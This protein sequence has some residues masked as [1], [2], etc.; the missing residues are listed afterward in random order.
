MG[1]S[2]LGGCFPVGT[3]NFKALFS[4]VKWML[5]RI[6]GNQ[7]QRRLRKL[8]PLVE[9]INPI[10]EDLK[11]WK[12]GDLRA[13]TV[14]WKDYLS[15][16]EEDV[17]YFA[18]RKIPHLEP[19]K[20]D[21]ILEGWETRFRRLEKDFPDAAGHAERIREARD[22]TEAEK[23]AAAIHRAQETYNRMREKFPDLRAAYLEEIL[24]TA[25]AV[26]KNTARRLCGKT[27]T[28]SDQPTPWD[29]VHFDVQLIGGAGLHQGNI[30]EMA[31]GEGKTLVAT[32]PVYLNALTGL[33]VHVITVNDYLAKRD[34][35][36]MGEL[37]RWLGLT[38][39]CI[40]N[41]MPPDARKE[42]Y[43]RDITYG[44]ASEFGFDYLRD[45]GMASTTEEQVQRGHYY[46]LIDEVDSILID[47]ARTPLI[48]SGPVASPMTPQ[49]ER[50][51]PLISQLVKKQQQ[52][53]NEFANDAK[54]AY[55]KGDLE[56]CGLHL[57][58]VKLGQPRH[59]QLLRMMEDAETRR[60]M[61]K[62][63]LSFYQDA[64]KRELFAIKEE[65]YFTIDEKQHDADLSEKGREFLNPEDPEAFVLPDLATSFSEIDGNPALTEEQ[66][67]ETKQKLQSEMD[68]QAQ[69]MHAVSQLLK[70]YCL[71]ER[72]VD[73]MVS[74]NK[75]VILDENTGRPMP[76]RRWSDG[77]HQAVEAKEGVKVDQETQTLATITIQNY[78]RMYEK[79]A[80]MTGTA[81][82]ESAEFKD[83]YG[84]NVLIVPTNKPVARFDHN[85]RVYKTQR[86]KLNAVVTHVKEAHATGQPMLLGTASERSSEI[87]SKMLKRERITHNVLNAKHHRQEAEIV[88]R[89]GHRGAVTVATNM[90]GRG[91]DIKLGEGV[92]EVGGLLVI[93]TERHPSRRIDRQ[94]RGRSGRQGDPGASIFYVSFEDD[95]MRQY[96]ASERMTKLMDRLNL[97]EGQE[98]EGTLLT[99]TIEMAQKKVEER[100]YLRRKWVLQYDDVM[101]QQRE[102]IYGYRNEVL[103]TEDPR[104]LILE[105][106]E[107]GIPARVE[108]YLGSEENDV[109]RDYDGLLGWAN[110][111]FPIRLSSEEADLPSKTHAEIEQLL[112]DRI[113]SA[114]HLKMEH[115]NPDHADEL[116][117]MI[118]LMA[119]DDLWR[120]HLYAMDG[121]REAIGWRAQ[122]QKDPLVEYK[123]E[124]YTLFVDLMDSIKLE[125]LNNLFRSTTNVEGFQAFL[126]KISSSKQDLADLFGGDQ[127]QQSARIAATQPQLR[128]EGEEEEEG[129]S[130]Q[131]PVRREM[132]KVGRNEPCPCGSGKKFKQCCGRKA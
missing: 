115:E 63:E 112:I 75:V 77:L 80:G 84:V 105:I 27:I 101:N 6:V 128:S 117:R 122:G 127:P 50:F 121:L 13:K 74:D 93:G 30:A 69:K 94:L 70:A 62:A 111:T 36:W 19:E 28:V 113:R 12:D 114:Y 15:R 119:I 64:Q 49:F 14:E 65:L 66:K 16:Y 51:K 129:P 52:L 108:Q 102:V 79:M 23:R 78:F 81:E 33:G 85:D 68:V 107:D 95:L 88:A 32:L 109:E 40:Q 48:I 18:E 3:A 98:L 45:N 5:R 60:S 35:E 118:L 1:R 61:E 59:R 55:E 58:R 26:V 72:D 54:K 21:E 87:L 39:G 97:E 83:I 43:G 67:E 29:M 2:R 91:T 104:A 38:V 103:Q 116:E 92:V 125:A 37:F 7:N 41:S 47:E 89:A 22:A 17:E 46:A 124:A 96:G 126:G 106:I 11:S 44:T 56:A 4:M 24:P 34:S 71:F 25:F 31:T 42:Q 123:K 10:E 20:V 82:T 8:W 53:C 120:E 100:N 130:I 76:G 86:E 90:A 73:Y 110:M 57:F 132:P 99:R 131:L 9:E